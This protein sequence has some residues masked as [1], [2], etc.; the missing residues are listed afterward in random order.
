MNVI[1]CIH[2]FW[3][4]FIFYVVKKLIVIF[5]NSMD[6]KN[7]FKI[8][9]YSNTQMLLTELFVHNIL[10]F[11][12]TQDIF[13]FS[14]INTKF[15][16]I[17]RDEKKS[18]IDMPNTNMI[19][20][21]WFNHYI[22]K[23]VHLYQKGDRVRY[24]RLNPIT[25]LIFPQ[26][27][28]HIL[29]IDKN[30][31]ILGTVIPNCNIV[32]KFENTLLVQKA[33]MMNSTNID[34]L[35]I[36]YENKDHRSISI[37]IVEEL[38]SADSFLPIYAFE[39]LDLSTLPSRKRFKMISNINNKTKWKFLDEIQPKIESSS[40][41][42]RVVDKITNNPLKS[43]ESILNRFPNGNQC[44]LLSLDEKR[45]YIISELEKCGHILSSKIHM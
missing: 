6:F 10:P 16:S 28:S 38:I 45:T 9:I 21:N 30:E 18:I 35:R 40:L 8:L 31:N 32:Q 7:D 29:L 22:G 44:T 33:I 19:S 41:I 4:K 37:Q 15:V 34:R 27:D 12:S 26:I 42:D 43:L 24:I 2:N 20:D 5:I 17:F 14:L 36:Y 13:N 3:R 25:E 11:C 23:L 39:V 1:N